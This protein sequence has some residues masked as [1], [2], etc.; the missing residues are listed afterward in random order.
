MHAEHRMRRGVRGVEQIAEV[1]FRDNHARKGFRTSQRWLM[2]FL[3]SSRNA[4]F[5]STTATW[6]TKIEKCGA[7]IE[8][9]GAPH[10]DS[11]FQAVKRCAGRTAE[12]TSPASA[13]R[14]RPH[15]QGRL[16]LDPTG[17]AA[18]CY[19]NLRP[20]RGRDLSAPAPGRTISRNRRRN[21][22]Q[23]NHHGNQTGRKVS[24][25]FIRSRKP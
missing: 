3:S 2:P 5:G 22:A 18:C 6:T 9:P 20:A 8:S 7:T 21:R 1:G 14:T 23:S 17:T 10:A 25:A 19:P 11:R 16:I 15:S 24:K 12:Q 13:V 4:E